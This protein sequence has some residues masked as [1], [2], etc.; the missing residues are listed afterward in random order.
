MRTFIPTRIAV[1][2]ERYVFVRETERM[3]WGHPVGSPDEVYRFEKRKVRFDD[4]SLCEGCDSPATVLFDGRPACDI[5][6]VRFYD[7]TV[8]YD[9]TRPGLIRPLLGG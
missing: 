9:E 3:V 2:P 6:A 4:P 8:P 5:C 1:K 7:M